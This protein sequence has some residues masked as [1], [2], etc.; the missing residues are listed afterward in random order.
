MRSSARTVVAAV[1]LVLSLLLPATA[2]A[3]IFPGCTPGVLPDGARSLICVPPLWN[4]QLFVYAH[5]FVP[6]GEGPSFE[7]PVLD[8]I[9]LPVLVQSLG[10]AFAATTYRDDGLVILEGVEDIRQLLTAF[11]AAHPEPALPRTHVFGVSEGGLVA[12]LLAERSPELVTSAVA[13]CAPIG[14]FRLQ[15]NYIGDFR[16]L[17]DYF[18]PGIIPGSAIHIPP[19]VIAQW[20]SFY[21]PYI[22]AALQANPERALELMR[23]SKAAFDPSNLATVI[24]TTINV[25]RYNILGAN[26]AA[27]KLGG[28]PFGNRQTLYVGSSNDLRLNLRVHRFV[29]SPLAL[30]EMQL[31]E[32]S[33]DLSVPL[34]TLHTTADEL[35]PFGHELLYIPKLDLVKR[36]RFVP[37]AVQRYGHCNFTTNELLGS[38]A[39]AISLP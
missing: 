36:G 37:L 13:A 9:P 5:G 35:V 27:Q 28:N 2:R 23:V 7:L 33:G 17:F 38:F 26:D 39:L 31:Y 18:F 32:T 20:E 14:N 22:A 3:Q 15:V 34:V 30:Q 24:T 1:A 21:V 11:K 10:F 12:T 19:P 8:G 4:G 6:P 25:L 16:V 29:A